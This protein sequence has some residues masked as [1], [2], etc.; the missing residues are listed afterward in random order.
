MKLLVFRVSQPSQA[1]RLRVR[2]F[3]GVRPVRDLTA[4]EGGSLPQAG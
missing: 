4:R 3:P 1:C 2:N